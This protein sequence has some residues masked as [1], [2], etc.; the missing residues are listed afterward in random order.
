M[1]RRDLEN[2]EMRILIWKW[3]GN[4]SGDGAARVSGFS[5][6]RLERRRDFS[7]SGL[8]D[9]L[10]SAV[11][12]SV[13]GDG[14]LTFGFNRKEQRTGMAVRETMKEA[15]MEMIVAMAMGAKSL[16]STPVRPSSGRKTRMMRMVA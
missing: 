16:P 3:I 11:F 6:Q 10:I 9:F 14:F 12:D 4:S 8:C 13:V 2:A 7:E 1:H 15:I 5:P